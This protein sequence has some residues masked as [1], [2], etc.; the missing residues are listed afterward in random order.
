MYMR[1]FSNG[2]LNFFFGKFC[3][4]YILDLLNFLTRNFVIKELPA[5]ENHVFVNMLLCSSDF[6]EVR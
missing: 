4:A 3:F 2:T 1:T 6:T 5:L